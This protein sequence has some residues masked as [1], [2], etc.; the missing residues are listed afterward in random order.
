MGFDLLVAKNARTQSGLGAITL[1]VV[2]IIIFVGGVAGYLVFRK[3]AAD[4]SSEVANP[5]SKTTKSSQLTQ[6][7]NSTEATP[8][9]QYL[10]IKEWSVQLPISSGYASLYY[11]LKPELP[12]VAYLSLKTVSDI[13]PDC[14]ANKVSLAA[15]GRLTQA[16][17][18]A[19]V[20]NPSVLNQPG[21]VHIGDYWYSFSK[22]N[23]GCIDSPEQ[24]AAI[25]KVQPSY[26]ISVIFKSLQATTN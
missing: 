13:A 20:K 21:T 16:L 19:A 18:D 17:Q 3:S 7:S 22:P 6:A 2:L 25:S 4:K 5:S 11:Y 1:L 10:V 23:T 9:K 24:S 15:V 14:A 8:A 26:D 12:D